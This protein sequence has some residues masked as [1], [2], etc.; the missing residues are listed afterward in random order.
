MDLQLSNHI[1]RPQRI[2]TLEL[3][4]KKTSATCDEN[5]PTS[6]VHI[7]RRALLPAVGMFNGAP[8]WRGI[9]YGWESITSVD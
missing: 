3:R 5:T 6:L 2:S 4:L 7:V 8:R 9:Q 1:L